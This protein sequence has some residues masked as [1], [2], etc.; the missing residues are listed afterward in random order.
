MPAEF[1]AGGAR[2]ARCIRRCGQ[3]GEVR[4]SR[5][6]TLLAVVLLLGAGGLGAKSLIRSRRVQLLGKI[7]SR[8]ETDQPVVALT[9]DD[10]PTTE[11]IDAI[12]TALSTHH[13]HATFF[14]NGSALAQTPRLGQRLVAA[15]H[16][17]GNHTYSH[18]GLILVGQRAISSEIERTDSLIHRAGQTGPIYFRPPYT[19]KLLALPYYLWRTHRTTITQDIEPETYLSAR[20]TPAEIVRYT[21]ARVHPGSIIL[22]HVW[23][24]SRSSSLA[25]VPLLLDSLDARGYCVD[26]VRTLTAL[27]DSSHLPAPSR[28][29][30]IRSTRAV[31]TAADA[32]P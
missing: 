22:L 4:R 1:G 18:R 7:V 16:E 32:D 30:A 15:G 9:F 13:A 17:L 19:H 29:C 6:L 14:V 27:A 26:A 8:V 20:A 11:A 28:R 3:R 5:W 10:G 25:A 23:Y 2:Q 12:L 24:P 31:S 21:L